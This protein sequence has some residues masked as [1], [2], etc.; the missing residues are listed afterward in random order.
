MWAQAVEFN[1]RPEMS[2]PNGYSRAVIVDHGRLIF[3]AGKWEWT[4]AVRLPTNS[5]RGQSGH[6]RI[7]R[8]VNDFVVGLNHEKLVAIRELATPSSIA[9]IRPRAPWFL[10]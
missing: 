7:S 1:N 2:S 3:A 5:L 8:R 10:A 6:L 4:S 9:S